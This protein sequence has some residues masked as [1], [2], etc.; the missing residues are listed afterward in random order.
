MAVNSMFDK[1]EVIAF[2]DSKA[3][4]WDENMMRDDAVID[5]ILKN[6]AV[7]AGLDV[8]DVACGTGV[9]F[10][11]YLKRNVRSLTGVDISPEMIRYAQAKFPGGQVKLLCGDVEEMRFDTQFDLVMVY[12]AFPHFPDP[13]RLIQ[14]LADLTKPGGRLS[15]AH[16][17]SRE[18][19]NACHTGAAH[20]VSNGLMPAQEL[21]MLFLPYFDGITAI[22]DDRMYQVTGIKR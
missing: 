9:L 4:L 18:Q 22:S 11:D 2:F 21:K 3:G 7:K 20:R 14:R 1:K 16:G 15:I 19:I 6:A 17:M 10:P 12:N 13:K 8:L 5:A